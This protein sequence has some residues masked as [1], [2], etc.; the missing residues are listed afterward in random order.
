MNTY[1]V[2]YTFSCQWRHKEDG[3]WYPETDSS[4]GRF[5]CLKKDIKKEVKNEI[6]DETYYG[7]ELKDIKIKITD[8]YLTTDCEI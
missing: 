6:I 7:E 8:C 1:W 2:E 3:K 4:A 5:R